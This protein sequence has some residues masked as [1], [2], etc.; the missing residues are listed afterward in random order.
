MVPKENKNNAYGGQ[1]KSIV[2]F[3]ETAY[4]NRPLHRLQQLLR[5]S[6]ALQTFR[7]H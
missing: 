3:S 2:V 7:V 1:T 6:R 4:C 5:L